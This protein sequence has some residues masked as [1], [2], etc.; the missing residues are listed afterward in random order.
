MAEM[1]RRETNYPCRPNFEGCTYALARSST[2]FDSVTSITFQLIGR[3]LGGWH[4]RA[5]QLYCTTQ[6][7]RRR[8]AVLSSKQDT[9]TGPAQNNVHQ[10]TCIGVGI[11][12]KLHRSPISHHRP[13]KHFRYQDHVYA[14]VI[15][16]PSA[17]K[18]NIF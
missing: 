12:G 13:G 6:A 4:K 3:R 2:E 5:K 11:T 16:T 8:V 10:L 9:A 18:Q 1:M 7:A 17:P 15:Q 14:S